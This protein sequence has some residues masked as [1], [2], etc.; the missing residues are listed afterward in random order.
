M[1]VKYLCVWRLILYCFSMFEEL[2]DIVIVLRYGG[3]YF[4]CLNNF[5]SRIMV[6][7]FLDLK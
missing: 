7:V 1:M 2:I 4:L 3:L 5:E 6:E